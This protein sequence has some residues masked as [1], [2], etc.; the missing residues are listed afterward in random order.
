MDVLAAPPA[1]SHPPGQ[2]PDLAGL[3][4]TNQTPTPPLRHEGLRRWLKIHVT[5]YNE[6]DFAATGI[7]TG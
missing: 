5:A 3:S 6:T 4:A 2:A 7:M 1:Q